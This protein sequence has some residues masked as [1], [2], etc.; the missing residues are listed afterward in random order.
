MPKKTS[1][2]MPSK[3]KILA[4]W[5]GPLD[6]EDRKDR[7][8]GFTHE[9]LR[10]PCDTDRCWACGCLENYE[11]MYPGVGKIERCHIVP[12]SMGGSNDP[13]N[14]FLMCSRCHRRSPDTN[15]PNI[16]FAWMEQ[17]YDDK[18]LSAKE[19]EKN[20]LQY[21]PEINGDDKKKN[22][23]NLLRLTECIYTKEFSEYYIN[24]SSYHFGIKNKVSTYVGL[25]RKY[26]D[27]KK[28]EFTG[29]Y[30]FPKY[31]EE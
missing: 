4:T 25:L 28:I 21:F 8:A 30:T 16:M 20:L 18:I 19:L 22:G 10:L 3:E 6:I 13:F 17:Q 11:E 1:Q 23:N 7:L 5:W 31:D 2:V 15:D 12:K 14:L 29:E 9:K 27:E 26:V 24:N